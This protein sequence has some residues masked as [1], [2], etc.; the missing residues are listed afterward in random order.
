MPHS[1]T[2]STATSDASELEHIISYAPT[3]D[4][5]F[6]SLS[7]SAISLNEFDDVL[8]SSHAVI[9]SPRSY[10]SVTSIPGSQTSQ[11][12]F[13]ITPKKLAQKYAF[14]MAP[15]T[16]SEEWEKLERLPPPSFTL[17]IPPQ[18]TNTIKRGSHKK[19][20]ATEKEHPLKNPFVST[21]TSP[22][23]FYAAPHRRKKTPETRHQH[24][25]EESKKRL[26]F[27]LSMYPWR[28]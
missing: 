14:Y 19:S 2:D 9:E 11:K 3:L 18:P 16:E 20:T 1:S 15:K 28:K 5:T 8:K 22:P 23:S 27:V 10:I 4:R 21:L 24:S 13:V 26:G 7:G 12:D 25:L 6:R 17:H